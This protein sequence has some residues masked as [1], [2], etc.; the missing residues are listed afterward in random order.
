M[1]DQWSTERMLVFAMVRATWAIVSG[2][3]SYTVGAGGAV[4]IPRPVY[5][6]A[7]AF[8]DTSPTLTTEYKLSFY[9][10]AA[11]EGTVLKTLTSPF[12]TSWYYDPFFP[13]GTLVLWPT[14]TSTT[15]QG[16]I[17]YP[18]AVARFPL[19]TTT[20][21][22]PPGYEEL[23]VTNLAIVLAASYSRQVDPSLRERAVNAKALVKRSNTRLVDLNFEAGSLVGNNRGTWDIRTGP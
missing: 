15:L 14:P 12:P 3:G 19:L 11:R 21:S 17:Y 4:N 23:L 13:L 8:Q 6:D 1:V 2:T 5:I 16:V 20:V 9:T 7:V 22:M 10:D 18:Q